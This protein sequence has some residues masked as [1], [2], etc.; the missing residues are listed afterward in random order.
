M[1][2]LQDS[3]QS[4][5]NEAYTRLEYE[6]GS[7]LDTMPTPVGGGLLPQE[8]LEKGDWLALAYRIGVDKIFFVNNDPVIVFHKFVE[9][10]GVDDI[11]AA[12]RRAWCMARPPC[13][14]VARPGE[15]SAYSLNQDPP[16]RIEDWHP[17]AVA[18]RVA[19]VA[20]KLRDY[21]R[22]QVESGQVFA[23]TRF[24]DLDQR[25]DRRLI[26]D[27]KTV[28][29]ALIN[30]GGNKLEPQYAHALIG[31]S[32]FIRYLEDR[33]IL[34][35]EYFEKVAWDNAE[36]QTY[37]AA[38]PEKPDLSLN[39][40]QRRYDRVL[41][42]KP[43]VYA[44]F[45]QLA[46]DFNGDM[47][48]IDEREEKSVKESHLLSL[49]KFLLGDIDPLQGGLFFWAYDFSVIPTELISS[50]YE[51]FYHTNTASDDKGTHYTP[52]ALVDYV[53]SQ[54][55]TE[56]RLNRPRILDTSCGSGV[57]L[58]ESFRR[59]VRHRMGRVGLPLTA[60]ELRHIIRDQLVGIEINT[61]AA[62][63]A[64]F[65]LYLA[66]LHYQEPSDIL[67]SPKLPNLIYNDAVGRDDSHYQCIINGDTF[68]LMNA[69][70]EVLRNELEEGTR[71]EG[72]TR[73]QKL[74][75]SPGVL[76]LETH[77]I[78]IIV[79]NPPWGFDAG[80]SPEMK[81]AQQQAHDWWETFEWSVGDK[82]FAQAFIARTLSL[83]K[84]GGQCG[85]LV[86]TGVFFKDHKNSREFRCR[87]LTQS[88][89]HSVINFAH[90]RQYFF[91]ANAPFAFVHYEATPPADDH[92]VVYWSAKKTVASRN[93]QA[94]VLNRADLR[95]V[96]QV[97]ARI[98]HQLWKV[99]WWGNHRDA[100]L[101]N[102]LKLNG[103]LGDL[104]TKREWPTPGRGFEAP[105]KGAKNVPSEWLRSY[106][107]LPTAQFERYGIIDEKVF[108]SVPDKVYRRGERSIYD[109][110]RLLIKRGIS[111]ADS[112]NGQI[113]ARL[114]D[115]SYCVKNSIHGVPMDKAEDW[116]RKVLTGILWSSLA[117]Y[118]FFM[119]AS[120]W[121]LWH[122]EIHLE[123]VVGL[124]IRLPRSA[125][126]RERIVSIVDEL[127]RSRTPVE[128]LPLFA[129]LDDQL[130]GQQ[131]MG[132]EQKLD[133]AIFDLY[134]LNE[135]ERDL[136]LDMCQY[137]LEYFYRRTGTNVVD[138]VPSARPQQ[139]RATDL[140]TGTATQRG[141]QGYIQAFLQ[142]WNRELAPTGEF[143]WQII[144]P[145]NN[146]MLA[147]VFT[148]I[149]KNDPIPRL[150]QSHDEAWNDVLRRCAE[151]LR[152]PVSRD[153]YIDGLVRAVTDT[154]IFIIRRNE[155]RLWT[156]SSGR[157]DAEA[158]LVQAMRFQSEA[159]HGRG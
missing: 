61:E 31:R 157:E 92:Q 107:Q 28:R 103:T 34:T 144:C 30:D 86:S 11:L 81:M 48:P 130:I 139:G 77:S 33:G 84:P 49:R 75:E 2:E 69:E 22:E 13:L 60:Q 112:A 66:L 154:S 50:I 55:L 125:S 85:L 64:S 124:P 12:F 8:W 76:P 110:W 70:R 120:S 29:K 36:W 119:T 78:D 88:V 132:L 95:R 42:S 53:L 58:A 67:E 127:R 23:D 16:K 135:G 147:V 80:T 40:T 109:G 128:S 4:L 158:T 136:V 142:I 24:G 113:K 35:P 116:E 131:L 96:Q 62:R 45:R 19:E 123:D 121:G 108:V 14:F 99:L 3:A 59:I 126:L 10:P 115:V 26:R 79:G 5:L 73:M 133:D 74:Y 134:E 41:R 114:E 140:P 89:L 18:N 149:D 17:L 93:R 56:S 94:V 117:R 9:P 83:L 54:I 143:Y 129:L 91:S 21:S 138:V 57:F 39:L 100:A 65:S 153:V 63:V 159:A 101:I 7:L 68:S 156:H 37:L 151:T 46:R 145:P 87:W 43:F 98:D 104:A 106:R 148:T 71:F 72:R 90:V 44:L 137:G 111:Q 105:L 32:I 1:I 82:E 152:V 51:E 155:R 52:L 20:E 122:D 15:L 47:F 27:L 146:P 25:A 141:I 118:Y 97:Y 102:T 150:P 6:Q 38:E